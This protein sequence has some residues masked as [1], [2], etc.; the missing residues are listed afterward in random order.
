MWPQGH[1]WPSFYVRD[2]SHVKCSV[3][4]DAVYEESADIVN[5]GL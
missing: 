5:H 3:C 4:A 2:Y 1:N